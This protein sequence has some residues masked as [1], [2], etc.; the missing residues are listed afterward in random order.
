MTRHEAID[1][2]PVWIDGR[3]ILFNSNRDGMFNLYRKSLG[4]DDAVALLAPQNGTNRFNEQFHQ[5]KV[6]FLQNS[7]CRWQIF[8]IIF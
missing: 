3:T 4:S 6:V 5:G 8:I 1:E 2:D 7:A